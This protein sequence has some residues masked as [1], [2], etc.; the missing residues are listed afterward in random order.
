MGAGQGAQEP[1]SRR[2]AHIGGV[3]GAG[4][5]IQLGFRSAASASGW[6]FLLGLRPGVGRCQRLWA[7]NVGG[8]SVMSIWGVG[9]GAGW[10]LAHEN[11]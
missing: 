2:C 11:T 10:L 6:G 1:E 3:R 8:V 4:L 5:G 9:D 7:G